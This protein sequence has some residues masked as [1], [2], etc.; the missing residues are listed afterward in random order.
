MFLIYGYLFMDFPIS[1]NYIFKIIAKVLEVKCRAYK[2]HKNVTFD[3]KIMGFVYQDLRSND[4]WLGY[5]IEKIHVLEV[6]YIHFFYTIYKLILCTI[7]IISFFF[8]Y[9]FVNINY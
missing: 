4:Y 9:F 5:L 3:F 2:S 6:K 8:F 1:F 7:P